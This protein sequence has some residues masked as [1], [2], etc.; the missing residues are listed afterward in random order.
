MIPLLERLESRELPS[1]GFAIPVAVLAPGATANLQQ[2][3]AVF[4]LAALAGS[5]GTTG[6]TGTA[7]AAQDLAL[8][9]VA[10]A[11]LMPSQGGHHAK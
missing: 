3:E 2:A 5:Q 9:F 10:E 6:A 1:Q 8:L 4:L 7:A 11:F